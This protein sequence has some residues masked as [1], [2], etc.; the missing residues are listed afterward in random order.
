MDQPPT[1]RQPLPPRLP[2]KNGCLYWCLGIFVGVPVLLAIIGY[3]VLMH[4]AVPLRL[5][6]KILNQDQQIRIEGIAGSIS[7]GFTIASIRYIDDSGNESILEGLALQWSDIGRMRKNRELV[8][9]QIGLRRAHLYIDTSD[10]TTQPKS[11]AT[12]TGS[13][14][15]ASSGNKL[16]LFEIKNV[17]IREVVIESTTGDFKLVLDETLMKGFRIKGD[18][19]D[20]ASLSIS[21]NFLDLHLEDAATATI[22]GEQIPFRRKVVGVLKPEMHKSLTKPIDFSIE[23]GAIAGQ[24]VTRFRGFNGSVEAVDLGPQGYEAITLNDFTPADTFAPE[25][26]GPVSKLSIEI[27]TGEEDPRTGLRPTQLVSGNL[28]LGTTLFTMAPQVLRKDLD[29]SNEH[30]E[31]MV[32]TSQRDGLEI[33]ATLK[34]SQEPPFYQVVL[35]SNPPREQHDL[36]ALLWF[37]KTYGDLTPDQAAEVDAAH[38][39]GLITFTPP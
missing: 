5:A 34:Q 36:L 30:S 17:D 26:S 11:E 12:P 15:T 6:A 9:D 33:T 8:I 2:S 39:K 14:S 24:M 28:T 7:R 10:D 3:Y 20:L 37:E 21:S 27:R 4:T 38:K 31:S 32:A 35:S 18:E 1:L 23:L 19:F 29:E 13:S 16:S 22:A 25:V